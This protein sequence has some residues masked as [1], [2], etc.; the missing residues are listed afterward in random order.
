L[1]N[2][3]N[4]QK[5]IS[6]SQQPK[7]AVKTSAGASSA[8]KNTAQGATQVATQVA[9]TPRS[10][11]SLAIAAGLPAD[12]LSASIISFARF[13]SLPLKPQLLADIRRNALMPQASQQAASQKSAPQTAAQSAQSL[14]LSAAA[15]ESK[16]VELQ[17]KALLQYAQAID[18]ESEQKHNEEQHRKHQNKDQ[19][20]Q[21]TPDSLKKMAQEYTEKNPLL[22]ILNTLPGKNGQRWIVIPLDFSKDNRDFKVSMRVLLNDCQIANRAVCMAL[23]VLDDKKQRFVFVMDSANEKPVKLT[24]YHQHEIQFKNQA[25]AKEELSRLFEIPAEHVFIVCNAETFPHETGC[26]ENF[27]AVDE[28]V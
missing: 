24:I 8:A 28:E 17:P 5:P 26:D 1:V 11:V 20:E 19:D 18:P 4:P 14:S 3:I 22:E 7:Q 6:V 16:G 21:I 10:A 23:D 27:Q 9:S 13:F 12:K 2:E 15:A 25:R